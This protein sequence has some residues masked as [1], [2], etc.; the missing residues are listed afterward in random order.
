LGALH[1]IIRVSSDGMKRIQILLT[2][3]QERAVR[4]R[5]AKSGRSIASVVRDAVERF[6][7][8]DDSAAT[9]R[10]VLQVF[11]KHASGAHDV[12]EKHDRYLG[13][14]FER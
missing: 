4:R 10:D 5:A 14:E 11:G 3:E 8:T 1:A 12:S 2:G 7:A 13:R 9:Q 6:V